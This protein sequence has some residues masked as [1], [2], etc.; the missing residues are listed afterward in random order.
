MDTLK[1]RI[2]DVERALEARKNEL[3]EL[4][5]LYDDIQRDLNRN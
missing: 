3:S 2:S 4:N 5:K 1:Y